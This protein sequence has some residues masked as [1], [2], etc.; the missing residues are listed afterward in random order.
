MSEIQKPVVVEEQKPVCRQR[1]S[2]YMPTRADLLTQSVAESA[3]PAPVVTESAPAPVVTESASAPVV[4]STPAPVAQEE[5]KPVEE[6]KPVV[7]ESKPEVAKEEFN[8]EGILGY[9][10]PGG[11]LK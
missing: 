5:T 3:T 7:E 6:S 8:G 11:F 2:F 10:A 4:E 9:K 1:D